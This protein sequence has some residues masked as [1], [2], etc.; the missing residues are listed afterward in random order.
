MLTRAARRR[1]GDAGRGVESTPTAALGR[2]LAGVAGGTVVI[3][4]PGSS[5]G[6]SDGL[7]VLG[8]LLDHLVD[9]VAGSHRHD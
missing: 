1:R 3:N 6:V 5:G 2:G 9:Q 7:A 4:L 8:E